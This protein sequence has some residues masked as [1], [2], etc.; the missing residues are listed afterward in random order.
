MIF[1]AWASAFMAPGRL[2]AE[3]A[4]P[5]PIRRSSVRIGLLFVF[6][7]ANA[8][9]IVGAPLVWLVKAMRAGEDL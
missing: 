9:I 3:F 1:A 6:L 5:P 2:P 8:L 7:A 4:G